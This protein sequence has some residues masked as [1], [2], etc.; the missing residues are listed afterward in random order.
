M[1]NGSSIFHKVSDEKSERASVRISSQPKNLA[2]CYKNTITSGNKS[3]SLSA[4]VGD[5][6]QL[7][8]SNAYIK[9]GLLVTDP[10]SQLHSS[11]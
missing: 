3:N 2:T 8:S 6:G 5:N 7:P 9:T 10:F 1:N 11:T 4:N